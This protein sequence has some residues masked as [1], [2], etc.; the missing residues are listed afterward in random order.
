[1]KQKPTNYGDDFCVLCQNQEVVQVYPAGVAQEGRIVKCVPCGLMFVSP[2]CRVELQDYREHG[3]DENAGWELSPSSIERQLNQVSDYKEALAKCVE[4]APGGRVLEVGCCT[5]TLLNELQNCGMS[6]VG[7][8]PNGFAARYGRAKY[9]LDIRTETLEESSLEEASFDVVLFLH[10]IE[11]VTDPKVTL[12]AIRRILKPGGLLVVETPRYDTVTF[13]AFG[14]HERNIVDNWHLY[15][16]SRDSLKQ[17]LVASGF[18]VVG[19]L[20]PGRTVTFS[21][22]VGGLGKALRWRF[23]EAIGQWLAKSKVN[24][25]LSFR[26]NLRDIYRVYAVPGEDV[27][28]V[29]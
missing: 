20:V 21:R 11:H 5:G 17:M 3:A 6:C 8:E 1:M 13:K 15:F 27:Q 22:L 12:Q 7:L 25:F 24:S 4:A 18:N 9:G 29:E 16:F 19:D 28:D 14:K 23:L 10:V 2:Q 26:L